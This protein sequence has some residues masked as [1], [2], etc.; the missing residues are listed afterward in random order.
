PRRFAATCAAPLKPTSAICTRATPSWSDAVPWNDF[1]LFA[2]TL[3]LRPLVTECGSSCGGGG[4]G[5]AACVVKT[6]SPP[7]NVPK[8]DCATARK[9]TVLDGA[10][11]LSP[12]LNP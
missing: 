12:A 10:S 11:P 3:L 9:W 7:V 4:G 5:G 6:W 8:S 1:S 2:L